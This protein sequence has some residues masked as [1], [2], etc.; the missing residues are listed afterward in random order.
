MSIS[1]VE[2][3][4]LLNPVIPEKF[5]LIYEMLYY[6]KIDAEELVGLT[7]DKIIFEESDEGIRE[8]LML[9]N[10]KF[11]LIS[12]DLFERII[13]YLE[14]NNKRWGTPESK[15]TD[16]NTFNFVFESNKKGHQY[17]IPTLY[18]KFK[19][20]CLKV[21]ILRDLALGS[22]INTD[23]G[24]FIS[25]INSELSNKNEKLMVS[26]FSFNSEQI[27]S[28]LRYYIVHLNYEEIIAYTRENTSYGI[29]EVFEY[30]YIV[31]ICYSFGNE[32]KYDVDDSQYEIENS[33]AVFVYGKPTIE[34]KS[35]M[36]DL[37][38]KVY[39]GA[40]NK[41]ISFVIDDPNSIVQKNMNT[42]LKSIFRRWV[43]YI[44][45]HNAESE[46]IGLL[47]TIEDFFIFILEK[48]NSTDSNTP[49]QEIIENFKL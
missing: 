37:I 10:G 44:P 23:L 9:N 42:I 29:K 46:N 13:N 3:Q 25:I 16:S 1:F 39:D 48:V 18:K 17:T 38:S 15:F 14:F 41:F 2:F 5:K 20:H 28:F 47:G 32:K 49:E 4:K 21:G 31:I 19:E 33:R 36:V 7:A 34:I 43:H 40:E 6:Y 8:G 22:L 30:P 35:D 45:L 11:L 12:S 24:R 27:S 26:F